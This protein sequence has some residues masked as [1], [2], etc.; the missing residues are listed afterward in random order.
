MDPINSINIKKDS[1]F[2]ILLESQK[3]NYTIYYMEIKDLYIY[4]N[5]AYS[6]TKI[7]NIQKDKKKW[8][9]IIKKKTI[10]LS[11]LDIIFMRKDPPV[12][13]EFIYSTYILE[14]AEKNG[15]IVVNKPSSLRNFNEKIFSIK[16]KKFIPET[17]I[18]S[19]KKIIKNFI[20]KNK[21]IIIKPLNGMGGH[22]IFRI[23]KKDKN[24]SVI[25]ETMTKKETKYCIVQK[26]VKEILNGDKRIIIINGI[27]IKWCVYRIPKK[28][29]NRGNIASGGK[30]KLKKINKKDLKIS[31][32][33]G[34][35]LIKKGI[36]IAGID[37]I[38]NKLIEINITS[39]TCIR[40]I[41]N[42]YKVSISEMLL[43]CLEK[44]ILKK[45][46]K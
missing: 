21:D 30:V 41:E 22:S 34:K 26:Y 25:V 4:L 1:T 42:F 8:F 46:I 19:K 29:E 15:T 3:R 36:I 16:F 23:K 28:G 9:K 45:N 18:T 44:K 14:K 33:I 13:M 38:G 39:P 37:I 10:L 43:N 7:I 24:F 31:K 5:K 12:N 2:S 27:P 35:F 11:K 20:K 17:L 40:E 6:N 32:R